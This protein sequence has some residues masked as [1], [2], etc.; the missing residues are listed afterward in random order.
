MKRHRATSEKNPRSLKEIILQSMI[1]PSPAEL[2][3][4][5]EWN[6]CHS[7]FSSQVIQAAFFPPNS[8][9][10]RKRFLLE[11]TI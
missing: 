1:L 10:T 7:V 8:R 6:F 2:G 3:V 4:T 5:T 9:M 11:N